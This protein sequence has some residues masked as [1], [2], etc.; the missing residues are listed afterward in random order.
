LEE[1]NSSL[2]AE[3]RILGIDHTHVGSELAKKWSFPG[4]LVDTIRHHHAPEKAGQQHTLIHIVYL[5]DLLMSRFHVGL[6]LERLDTEIL[7]ERLTTVGFTLDQFP[8]IVDLIPVQVFG[9]SP[10]LALRQRNG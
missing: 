7:S 1:A 9:S 5:A 2:E 3:R 8:D 4:S 6:E 10:E